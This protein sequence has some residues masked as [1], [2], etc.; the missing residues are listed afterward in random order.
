MLKGLFIDKKGT[1][2][3]ILEYG[4]SY[5][6]QQIHYTINENIQADIITTSTQELIIIEN[7]YSNI[8]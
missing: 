2:N 7:C 5:F 3:N 8:P 6:S 1:L 4:I